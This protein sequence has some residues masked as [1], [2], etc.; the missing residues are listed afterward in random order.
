MASTDGPTPDPNLEIRTS[1]PFGLK[2]RTW[3][4][5]A[6]VEFQTRCAFVAHVSQQAPDAC[7]AGVK[8]SDP[9]LFWACSAEVRA[10]APQESPLRANSSQWHAVVQASQN[11][12]HGSARGNSGFAAFRR[13]RLAAAA[14]TS[15]APSVAG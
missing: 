9:D 1:K 11:A 12:R 2:D 13:E 8:Y 14:S 10:T 4:H 5:G 7:A 15:P 3:P 6:D